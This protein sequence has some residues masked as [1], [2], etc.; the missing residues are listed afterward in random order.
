MQMLAVAWSLF[1]P[2][3]RGESKRQ[4]E[5]ETGKRKEKGKGKR[6]RTR[7]RI[8]NPEYKGLHLEAH[9]HGARAQACIFRTLE[10]SHLKEA[11]VQ[12][13]ECQSHV[14][15]GSGGK[16]AQETPRRKHHGGIRGHHG[17]GIWMR[18]H[19]ESIKEAI[20]KASRRRHLGKVNSVPSI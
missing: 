9:D 1:L 7:Q 18:H 3:S 14:K 2:S 20:S 11:P 10:R 13:A 12:E 6:E 8:R 5:S 4:G 17:G 19:A 16:I 15:G